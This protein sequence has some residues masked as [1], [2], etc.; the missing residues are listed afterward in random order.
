MNITFPS[1]K[2]RPTAIALSGLGMV[3]AHLRLAQLEMMRRISQG[4]TSEMIGPGGIE[5]DHALRAFHFGRNVPLDKHRYVYLN[6]TRQV[7][8]RISVDG[9]NHYLM[10]VA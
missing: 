3:H 4:R 6:N 7:V 1:S 8:G 9:I 5:L 10:N 2:R